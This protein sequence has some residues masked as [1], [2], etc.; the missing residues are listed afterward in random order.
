MRQGDEIRQEVILMAAPLSLIEEH[1]QLLMRCGLQPVAIDAAP[2]AMARALENQGETAG[3]GGG[4][5]IGMDTP[6]QFILDVG[7]TS[8]KAV[9]ARYGHVMF[10]R[11]LIWVAASSIRSWQA[12]WAFRSPK[13]LNCVGG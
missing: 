11:S 5:N 10:S 1:A 7:H 6:A 13:R 12:S 3:A 2:A 4:G 8:A 9:V